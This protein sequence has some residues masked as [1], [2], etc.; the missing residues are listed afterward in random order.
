MRN[1]LLASA[2]VGVL[3]LAAPAAH[4]N[5]IINA[6]GGAG[7]VNVANSTT[8]IANGNATLANG[9]TIVVTGSSNAPGAAGLAELF[10]STTQIVNNATTAQTVTLFF[11]QNGFSDPTVP[12]NA[13]LTNNFSGTWTNNSGTSTGGA[14]GCVD[15]SNTATVTEIACPSGSTSTA[16]QSGSVSTANGSFSVPPE[17]ISV[18]SP[19]TTYALA[20]QI[21]IS[22]APGGNFNL[23]NSE[24]LQAVGEPASLALIGV[25]LL[26]LGF[27]SRKRA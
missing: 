3:A 26:G 24:S 23:T 22:I 21:A 5:L 14:L 16:I 25:G 19:L 9:V 12:P 6:Q 27:V 4:A 18:T 11:V 10:S 7:V 20:E 1:I 17:S 13:T 2:A 15:P 8:D